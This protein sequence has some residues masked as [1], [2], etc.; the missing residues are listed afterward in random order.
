MI[1]ALICPLTRMPCMGKKCITLVEEFTPGLNHY[2]Y[3]C[4]ALSIRIFFDIDNN[5]I[6]SR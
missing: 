3:W 1:N 6:N 5:V 2:R 4:K